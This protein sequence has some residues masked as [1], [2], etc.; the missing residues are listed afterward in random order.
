LQANAQPLRKQKAPP[1]WRGFSFIRCTASA[2]LALLAALAGAILLLLLA[3]L[4]AALLLLPRLLALL[5]LLTRLLVGVLVR[6]L[7][8]LRCPLGWFEV[9]TSIAPGPNGGTMR[10]PRIRSRSKCRAIL[11]QKRWN[12]PQPRLLNRAV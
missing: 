5:L 11:K 3:G 7:I 1:A 2:A 8:H 6:I 10:G 9:L 12:P 4:L